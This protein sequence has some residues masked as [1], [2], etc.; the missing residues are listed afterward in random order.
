M[1]PSVPGVGDMET[2]GVQ[3]DPY[4]K[5][6]VIK[7]YHLCPDFVEKHAFLSLPSVSPLWIIFHEIFYVSFPITL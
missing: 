4:L 6:T 7:K 1:L 2:G 3:K 5:T